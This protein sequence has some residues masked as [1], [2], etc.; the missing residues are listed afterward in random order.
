MH[1]SGVTEGSL[2][3]ALL[4]HQQL[5]AA[6]LLQNIQSPMVQVRFSLILCILKPECWAGTGWRG[7]ACSCGNACS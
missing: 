2:D 4:K 7:E 6:Y 5:L 1:S 3:P